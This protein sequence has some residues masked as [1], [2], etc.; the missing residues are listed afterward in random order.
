MS[1]QL[2]IAVN[3]TYEFDLTKETVS[4]CDI[5]SSSLNEYHVLNDTVSYKGTVLKSNFNKKKYSVNV[6]DKVYEVTISDDL[7]Q[8][9]TKMGFSV[10][11]DKLVDAIYAPMPGLLLEINVTVGQ[12][13]HK[14]DPLLIL[15]AMKMEN[16]IISPRDG[17]IKSIHSLKGDALEKNQLLIEF[18]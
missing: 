4:K 1:D 8:L 3:D 6:N 2:K 7:D 16:S 15:E 13:V 5:I 18:E 17:I 9:I 12:E 14:D 10:N 11:D